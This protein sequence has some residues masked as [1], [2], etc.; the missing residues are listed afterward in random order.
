M[1][2]LEKEIE[3][4]LMEEEINIEVNGKKI[5]MISSQVKLGKYFLD[6]L[7]KDSDSNIYAIELK[8]GI[9]DGNALSQVLAYM[10]IIE[11]FNSQTNYK[12]PI[13]GV[14]IGDSLS[15]YMENAIN[16]VHNVFFVKYKK[17]FSYKE[18]VLT[19]KSDYITQDDI[20]KN[21]E[22]FNDLTIGEERAITEFNNRQ[23]K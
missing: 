5:Y 21:C 18:Q 11:L 17:M 14:L 6:V 20:K 15:P 16:Q 3:N 23:V 19:W 10:D 13:Y 1:E 4:Y 9:V 8:K 7:G 2:Q 22:I 12:K